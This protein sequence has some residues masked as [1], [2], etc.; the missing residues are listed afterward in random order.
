MAKKRPMNYIQLAAVIAILTV[1]G[2]LA[3]TS[4]TISGAIGWGKY[5]PNHICVPE[6]TADLIVA[7][8][9]NNC[10]KA[11]TPLGC[12]YWVPAHSKGG[13]KE[14]L[15]RVVCNVGYASITAPNN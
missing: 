15:V 6:K 4:P 14:D 7:N 2:S 13:E 8:D 3:L 1:V 5:H 9:P 11:V 12:K 10:F